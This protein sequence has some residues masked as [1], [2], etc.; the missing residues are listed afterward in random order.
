[1]DNALKAISSTPDELRVANYIVLFG[2]RDLEGIATPR[3]N[4]DGSIGEYFAPDTALD[5]PAT[6]AGRL[7]VDW[8]HRNA[9][10]GEDP[11]REHDDGQGT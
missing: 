10:E 1:M 9:P 8:E 11:G 2:G 5:S 4:R 3:R 6:K 7:P